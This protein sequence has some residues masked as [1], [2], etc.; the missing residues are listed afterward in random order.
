VAASDPPSPDVLAVLHYL[1]AK[2]DDEPTWPQTTSEAYRL[3]WWYI[4]RLAGIDA[5]YPRR[6]EQGGPGG[7]AVGPPAPAVVVTSLQPDALAALQGAIR[8]LSGAGILLS[9]AGQDITIAAT[10]GP[11]Q[12]YDNLLAA[13]AASIDTGTFATT[14]TNALVLGQFRTDQ[15]VTLSSILCRFN[16]DAGANYDSEQV[17][18]N[19]ASIVNN[20]GF[21]ATSLNFD[22]PG[23]SADANRFSIVHLDL[24]NYAGSTWKTVNFQATEIAT[25]STANSRYKLGGGVY[26]S[27]T[28]ISRIQILPGGGTNLVAGS[29]LTVYGLA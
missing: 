20:S 17:F 4:K 16:N 18:W 21:A 9:E 7:Q 2:F 11:T 25:A 23:A 19:G 26:R 27:T 22:A 8:L 1:Q 10:P 6:D 24:I 29:R 5:S 15:A 14:Y 3:Q 13:P 12:L 28:P